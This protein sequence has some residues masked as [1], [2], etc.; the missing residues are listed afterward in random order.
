M[1]VSRG[2]LKRLILD[3]MARLDE[4]CGCPGASPPPA[5]PP[6]PPPVDHDDYSLSMPHPEPDLGGKVLS[7]EEALKVVMIIAANTSCPVTSDALMGVVD[8]LSHAEGESMD[9][10]GPERTDVDF[11]W[12]NPEYGHAT[13]NIEDL[14][15]QGAFS[16][17]FGMGD[18]GDF[19]DVMD[20]D[21]RTSAERRSGG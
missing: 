19:A 1:L 5:S 17:G 4:D 10:S 11:D 18:S 9:L 12:H 15:P 6:P 21:T 20:S 16:L 14:D 7:R 8:D 3:E 13:G 2:Q